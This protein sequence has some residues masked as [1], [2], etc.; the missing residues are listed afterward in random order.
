[1]FGGYTRFILRL[2]QI[3]NLF[4]LRI[5]DIRLSTW[6]PST[7]LAWIAVMTSPHSNEA[8]ASKPT[9]N[10]SRR[11]FLKNAAIGTSGVALGSMVMS[12]VEDQVAHAT[13]RVN[14]NSRPSNLKITDVRVVV[15]EGV[16]FNSPIVRIDTNQGISGLGEVRDDANPE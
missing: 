10:S 6:T 11:R 1:M 16:P 7:L 12:P 14:K 13:S 2:C 3:H 5:I 8:S 9:P 15:L 4:V